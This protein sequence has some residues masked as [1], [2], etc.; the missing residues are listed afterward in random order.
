MA[1]VP[2]LVVS[3]DR[4]AD[5]WY[6]FFQLFWRRWPDCAG[7][8]YLGTNFEAYND[9]RVQTLRIGRD[10]AWAASLSTML[11]QIKSDYVIL[12]L[13]DFLLTQRVDNDRIKRLTAIASAEQLGC[14]RL[15][16]IFP[17]ATAVAHH[18]ELGSFTPGE[19]WRITAQA[20]IWRVETLRKLLVP[21]FSAWDFELVGSLMSEFMP[22]QIWGVREPALV[23]DHAIE[24]GRWRP[25]GI[26][27]CDAAGIE[28]DF[29]VRGAFT[30]AE[31]DGHAKAGAESSTL[32]AEKTEAIR[33]FKEGRRWTGLR[34][35]LWCL[36]RRPTS[37]QLWTIAAAGCLGSRPIVALQRMHLR[38]KVARATRRYNRALRSMSSDPGTVRPATE[39][40]RQR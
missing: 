33:D 27:I 18:P 10:V 28:V 23:Y 29:S 37:L 7:P 9:P 21:G 1:D 36:Q 25:Q 40:G 39:T 2:V 3:C 11:E 38:A 13:E 17:P 15:Y 12:M 8:V 6:P 19:D 16:S 14:L 5:L 20:A 30:A 35:V 4:Y 34:K 26:A 22:D 32:A 24:K 31:L